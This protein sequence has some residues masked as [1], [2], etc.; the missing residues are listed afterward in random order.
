MTPLRRTFARLGLCV[1]LSLANRAWAEDRLLLIVA[2]QSRIESLSSI[3]VHKLFLGLTVVVNDHRLRPLRNDSDDLM[4]RV[5]FQSVVSM[6]E[7]VYDRRMLALT[8]QQGVAAPPVL[9]S[10]REVLQELAADPD[11]VSFAWAAEVERDPRIKVL[12]VLWK[13]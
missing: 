10:T 11:A 7:S 6:S 12:R 4:R 3:D 9:R 5:F 13:R 2:A 1:L 8:L